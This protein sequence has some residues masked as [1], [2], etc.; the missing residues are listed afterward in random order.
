MKKIIFLLCAIATVALNAKADEVT[1]A[2]FEEGGPTE[3]IV[4][5]VENGSTGDCPYLTLDGIVP[6]TLTSQVNGKQNNSANVYAIHLTDVNNSHGN[7]YNDGIFLHFNN[8]NY[9][10][11][12]YRYLH[13]A[14]RSSIRKIEL[15]G[16][17]IDGFQD[18]LTGSYKNGGT[19]LDLDGNGQN[20]AP[21]DEWFD[22]VVTLKNNTTLDNNYNFW[23]KLDTRAYD[24]VAN[25]YLYIDEIVLS[26]DPN[27][28]TIIPTVPPVPPTRLEAFDFFPIISNWETPGIAAATSPNGSILDVNEIVT[29]TTADVAN[30]N[31]TAGSYHIS[32]NSTTGNWDNGLNITFPKSFTV[33]NTTNR[34]LHLYFRTSLTR[35]EIMLNGTNTDVGNF[36]PSGT[37]PTPQAKSTVG[38]QVFTTFNGGDSNLWFDYVIDLSKFINGTTLSSIRIAINNTNVWD[39]P[40]IPTG[41]YATGYNQNK[42]LYIDEIIVSNSSTLR[43]SIP[44]YWQWTGTSDGNWNNRANWTNNVPAF[45][46]TNVFIPGGLANYPVL[47]TDQP[48]PIIAGDITYNDC[49]DLTL[50][51]GA[52]ISR[53]DRLNYDKARVQM[54]LKTTD[55][56]PFIELG[57]WY[58]LSMPIQGV[59]SGDIAFGGEPSVFLRK[60]DAAGSTANSYIS[61]KWTN[62][63][64]SNQIEFAPGEGFILWVNGPSNGNGRMANLTAINNVLELPCFFNVQE[65][66]VSLGSD[67]HKNKAN[68]FHQHD[69]QISAGV[70]NGHSRFE[71]FTTP[72]GVPTPSGTFEPDYA[73]NIQAHH[74]NTGNVTIQVKFVDGLALIGNPYLSSINFAK[75]AADNSSVIK[76]LGYDIF[77]GDHMENALTDTI[78]PFQSFI[79]EKLDEINNGEEVSLTFN[80]ANVSVATP[81]TIGHLRDAAPAINQLEIIA[82]NGGVAS[83][84]TQIRQSA[85]GS[86]QFGNQDMRALIMDLTGI[87]EVYTLKDF[88]S[89]SIGACINTVSEEAVLIPLA[90]A[91]TYAG[92]MSFTFNGMD[93]YSAQITLID[94]LLG[95]ETPL[96]GSS[97]TYVFDYTPK[98]VSGQAAANEERFALQFVPNAPTG[99]NAPVNEA[100]SV[101]RKEST[102]YAVSTPSNPIRSVEIYTAQGVR[103]YAQTGLNVPSYSVTRHNAGTEIL[104]VKLTTD[105]GIKNVKL[106]NQ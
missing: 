1:L 38:N 76:S 43:A 11:N 55:T 73:R 106:I 16:S 97:Q 94:Y 44:A 102:I 13:I 104:I 63:Y 64:T 81:A 54:N 67:F 24:N 77:D 79:I 25:T 41:S 74:L 42:E 58:M 46:S 39:P 51:Y 12:T 35:I 21:Q 37:S 2:N 18:N 52:Q 31:A 17:Q 65:E 6:N 72:G 56:N 96:T 5:E 86:M 48:R 19:R 78:A 91:T 9:S 10:T 34:F 57:R 83:G 40:Y 29:N 93:N 88:Q 36:D 103:I 71:W 99:I 89:A 66:A 87:P 4:Q 15:E 60:F 33:N 101:Y 70:H 59:V 85:E 26:T 84:R 28:R 47:L 90:V 45:E 98:T 49:K 8:T 68:P 22:F 105:K 7:G 14:M 75:F 50:G 82:S 30:G 61:G 20:R 100:V 95:T 3:I 80:I 92:S 27:P 62:Y 53:L 23:V 69:G 32:T